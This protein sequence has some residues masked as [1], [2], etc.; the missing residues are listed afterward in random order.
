[1]EVHSCAVRGCRIEG[2]ATAD[3]KGQ[4]EVVSDAHD[5]VFEDNELAGGDGG[6]GKPA[7]HI[8]E[9][10]RHVFVS[11]NHITGCATEVEAGPDS[12]VATAPDIECGYGTAAE[13]AFR[14]LPV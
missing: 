9:T 2:N 14:H 6:A 11:G 5:L 8:A 10:A 12:L 4:I 13:T 3:G 1:V 7:F